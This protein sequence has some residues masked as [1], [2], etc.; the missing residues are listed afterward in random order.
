MDDKVVKFAV[1]DFENSYTFTVCTKCNAIIES[2]YFGFHTSI[3]NKILILYVLLKCS[4]HKNL[5]K[6]IDS[7]NKM[8]YDIETT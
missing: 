8:I 3:E 1:Y 6:K 7:G 5:I 2:K 4:I